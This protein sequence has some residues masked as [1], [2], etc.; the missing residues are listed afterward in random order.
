[1]TTLHQEDFFLKG[2]KCLFSPQQ[3]EFLG[4]IV[5][6]EGVAPEQSKVQA[7]LD[8]HRPGFGRPIHGFLGLTGFYR[9]FFKGYALI[10]PPLTNLLKKGDFLW[11]T[12]T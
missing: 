3:L 8:W 4:H 5:S 11:T 10:E 2:S 12:T 7:M 1:M 9:R 6:Q